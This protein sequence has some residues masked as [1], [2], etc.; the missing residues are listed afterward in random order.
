MAYP[1]KTQA[2][3][4]ISSGADAAIGVVANADTPGAESSSPSFGSR[5][6]RYT[7]IYWIF[8]TTDHPKA[9]IA[10]F[11]IVAIICSTI[12]IASF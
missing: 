10:A 3:E 7:P 12:L 11:T 9:S 4:K 8:E 1:E 5:V 6:L 2:A